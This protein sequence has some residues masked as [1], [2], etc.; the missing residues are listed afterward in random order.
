MGWRLNATRRNPLRNFREFVRIRRTG[1]WGMVDESILKD[2]VRASFD[3]EGY[4]SNSVQYDV[5]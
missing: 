1:L 2:A 3:F 5:G 4:R